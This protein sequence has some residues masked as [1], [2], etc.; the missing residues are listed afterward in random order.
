MAGNGRNSPSQPDLTIHSGD[1]KPVAAEPENAR[2]GNRSRPGTRNLGGAPVCDSPVMRPARSEASALK[3]GA[4]RLST[5]GRIAP[6]AS[7]DAS[8]PDGGLVVT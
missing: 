6:Y 4:S 7:D 8:A 2:Q 5:T 1:F 3:D